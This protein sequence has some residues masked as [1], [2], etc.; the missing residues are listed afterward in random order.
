MTA[1]DFAP[2]HT[3]TADRLSSTIG[4]EIRGI[5]LA[6]DLNEATV[7][8]L[9]KALLDHKVLFLWAG[10]G[11]A[12]PRRPLPNIPGSPPPRTR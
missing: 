12:E 7:A 8:E 4:A 3:F 2:S 1:V 11:P 9:R 10:S 6:H 5:D